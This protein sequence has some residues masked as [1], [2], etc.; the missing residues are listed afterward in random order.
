MKLRAYLIDT[1]IKYHQLADILGISPT[2]MRRLMSGRLI[3]GYHLLVRIENATGNKVKA[4]DF[5]TVLCKRKKRIPKPK[6]EQMDI[7][8]I[9]KHKEKFESLVKYGNA[10]E[11]PPNWGEIL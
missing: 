3:P 1:G 7:K 10:D 8:D 5:G 4:E 2:Y 9:M 11:F 6:F